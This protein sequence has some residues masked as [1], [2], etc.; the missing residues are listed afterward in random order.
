MLTPQFEPDGVAC[1]AA[2]AGAHKLAAQ[3]LGR[4]RIL[5]DAAVRHEVAAFP[6]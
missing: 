3:D 4:R 6:R 5:G 2:I 1:C